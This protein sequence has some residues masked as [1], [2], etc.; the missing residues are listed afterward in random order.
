MTMA[1]ERPTA[2]SNAK[3]ALFPPH[4]GPRPRVTVDQG[5]RRL[6][7]RFPSSTPYFSYCID[8]KG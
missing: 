4:N 2:I 6:R 7:R 1:N 3:I 8:G 5:W